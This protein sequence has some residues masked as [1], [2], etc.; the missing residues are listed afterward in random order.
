M[1]ILFYN[2]LLALF[3]R[4]NY[5]LLLQN[6][7]VLNFMPC[8]V[9]FCDKLKMLNSIQN[10]NVKIELFPLKN[11][12][13]VIGLFLLAVI[14]I[15]T[16]ASGNRKFSNKRIE[17]QPCQLTINPLLRQANNWSSQKSI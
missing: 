15:N 6:E 17:N 5:L 9:F 7:K 13:H 1:F 10:I 14:N 11:L 12:P 16:I 3:H 2:L 8:R 4:K